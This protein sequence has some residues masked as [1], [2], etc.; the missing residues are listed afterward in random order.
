[1]D[2]SSKTWIKAIAHYCSR[3]ERCFWQ[4]RRHFA[5][6]VDLSEEEWEQVEKFLSME[7]YIDEQRF[8]DAYAHDKMRFAKWGAHKIAFELRQMN[9]ASDAIEQALIR[10][11]QRCE[12]KNFLMDILVQKSSTIKSDIPISKR[13]A[14]LIR[15]AQSRGFAFDD[16][17]RTV[18]H[19]IDFGDEEDSESVESTR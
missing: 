8:A 17:I 18:N 1:M 7:R 16:I 19:L 6:K 14:K 4:V 12:D 15:F 13:K 5:T 3:S 11:E 9:I 2:I 10:A